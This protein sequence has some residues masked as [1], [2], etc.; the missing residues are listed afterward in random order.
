MSP[1]SEAI[2]QKI[3]RL[4]KTEKDPEK[5]ELL[6]AHKRRFEMIKKVGLERTRAIV[7][8]LGIQLDP[9]DWK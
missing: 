5:R 7:A 4:L 1:E 9:T 2:L 6:M 8:A 3:N